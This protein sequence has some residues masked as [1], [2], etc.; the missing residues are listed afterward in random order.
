MIRLGFLIILFGVALWIWPITV[1]L[2][3]HSILHAGSVLLLE[4]TV[5]ALT[6]LS[7][8]RLMCQRDRK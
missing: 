5:P 6:I 8:G 1:L 4:L 2:T 7:A 3:S